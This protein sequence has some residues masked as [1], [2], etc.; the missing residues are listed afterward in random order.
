MAASAVFFPFFINILE[1]T[2]CRR[3]EEESDGFL[4]SAVSPM[5]DGLEFIDVPLD[6]LLE[7][8]MPDYLGEL[9]F[10]S[11]DYKVKHT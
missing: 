5:A 7:S 9:R 11:L 6:V 10:G 4:V 2:W 8:L 3:S 1:S